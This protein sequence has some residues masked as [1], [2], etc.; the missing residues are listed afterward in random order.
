ML[1]L[2]IEPTELWD[3][4]NEEFVYTDK[5][6]LK[7]EH[8]LAAISKWESK[9]CK[10][11]I[12]E[13]PKTKKEI[14]YYVKCMT[15]NEVDDVI[16][17]Y[18]DTNHLKKIYEYM[19]A[20]MT[21]TWFSKKENTKNR[22]VITSEIIYYWMTALNI[23]FV[24]E[25]WHFNRLMTLIKVCNEEQKPKEKLKPNELYRRNSML[26]NSRKKMSKK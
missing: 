4:T 2:V 23:P 5:Q 6:I 14:M 19:E 18:L 22:N 11:F 20:P 26:N 9:Y 3:E 8:S 17:T 1:E 24:C 10:P 21:A 15:L 25:N 16:Y 12:S 7:L 13:E